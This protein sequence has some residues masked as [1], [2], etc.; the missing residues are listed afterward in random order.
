[1]SNRLWQA[2][3]SLKINSN[4]YNFEGFISK[5]NN[6]KFNQNYS[7]ILKWSISDSDNFWDSIWV[8]CMIKGV[9]RKKK[10]YKSKNFYKNL[11]FPK[12][13]L[14]FAENLLSKNNNDKAITFISEN[15]F[16]KELSWKQLNKNVI[17]MENVTIL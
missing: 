4:L 1:M 13:K 10:I 6:K 15:G 7:N 11:F 12:S 2:S 16:R 5:R 9:K 3:R 8:F 17:K 14:N